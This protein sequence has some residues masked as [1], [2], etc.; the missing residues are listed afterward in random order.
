LHVTSLT[1]GASAQHL[2]FCKGSCGNAEK[3][4]VEKSME[5]VDLDSYFRSLAREEAERVFEIKGK[6]TAPHVDA[7]ADDYRGRL[8]RILAK[9]YVSIGEVA[10]LLNCSDSYVRKLVKRAQKKESRHPIPFA[11]L[12]G[13]IVFELSKL[14]EWVEQPKHRLRAAS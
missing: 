2:S 11:D 8:N 5:R 3:N 4:K 9:K 13:H 14:L 6:A 10:L 1:P 12:D 7:Q